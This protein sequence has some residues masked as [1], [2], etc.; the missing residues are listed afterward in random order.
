[1]LGTT[2]FFWLGLLALAVIL[3]LMLSNQQQQELRLWQELQQIQ[4]AKDKGVRKI[5][6]EAV[7]RGILFYDINP[8]QPAEP[9]VFFELRD[10]P[11]TACEAGSYRN[12]CA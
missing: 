8:D 2:V 10:V 4:T 12:G 1:M 5:A 3:K 9:P 7:G 11:V 6:T